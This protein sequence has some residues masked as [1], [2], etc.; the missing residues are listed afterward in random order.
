MIAN[1]TYVIA[2]KMTTGGAFF[3]TGF[4]GLYMEG[5]FSAIL[6]YFS[7]RTFRVCGNSPCEDFEKSGLIT[8]NEL[9]S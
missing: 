2:S 3:V 5:L 6:G 9:K 8:V 1:I 7:Y 4:G